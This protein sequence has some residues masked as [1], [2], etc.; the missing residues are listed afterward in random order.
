MGDPVVDQPNANLIN[1]P[2]FE[3]MIPR[4]DHAKTQFLNGP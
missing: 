3:E 4:Q 1:R 2:Y